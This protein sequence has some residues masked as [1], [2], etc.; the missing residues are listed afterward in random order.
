MKKYEVTLNRYIEVKS[1]KKDF[2]GDTAPSG[3][4]DANWFRPLCDQIL[5][6]F[7]KLM[8]IYQALEEEK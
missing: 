5:T 6:Q 4:G 1:S 7:S 3:A 2:S 8:E